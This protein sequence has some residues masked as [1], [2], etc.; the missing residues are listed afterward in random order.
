MRVEITQSAQKEIEKL[1]DQILPGIRQKILAL[2]DEPIPRG[3][4]K[5]E[6]S[7]YY[8]VR[9]GNYRIIYMLDKVSQ[10]V[11]ITR[12]RHRREVYR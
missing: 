4:K 7:D 5:L 12:V 10:R 2:A 8:R 1:P 11:V 9:V 6:G 3:S